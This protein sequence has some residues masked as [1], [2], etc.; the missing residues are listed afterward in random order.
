MKTL[1]LLLF[2]LSLNIFTSKAQEVEI[3]KFPEMKDIMTAPA[4]EEIS[5]INF[6]A[7]WCGP[8]VKEMPYFET[9]QQQYRDK[10]VKVYLISL[11][12][13]DKLERVK[14]LLQKKNIKSTVKLLDEPDYN[15]WIDKVEPEWSGAIPATLVINHKKNKREFHE[16]E[17]DQQALLDLVKK[18]Q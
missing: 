9:L 4:E 18:V 3:I 5:V 11:D 17:L 13:P 14:K 12:D 10:G 8:C 6:W 16:G 1:N 2:F 7:T 15:S